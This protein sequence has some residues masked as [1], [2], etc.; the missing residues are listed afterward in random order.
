[1]N[2]Q[3]RL[4]I[5]WSISIRTCVLRLSVFVSLHEMI[6]GFCLS[7]IA[8]NTVVTLRSNLGTTVHTRHGLDLCPYHLGFTFAGMLYFVDSKDSD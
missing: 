1:M 5:S 8:G 6:L 3:P 7:E 4:Y 2:T